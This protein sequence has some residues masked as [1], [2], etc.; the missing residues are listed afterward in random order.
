MKFSQILSSILSFVVLIFTI[1]CSKKTEYIPLTEPH[2][3]IVYT[4]ADFE[5]INLEDKKTAIKKFTNYRGVIEVE[6]LHRFIPQKDND[7]ELY[8][9]QIKCLSEWKCPEGKAI[10]S[11]GSF[12]MNPKFSYGENPSYGS[13]GYFILQSSVKS[14]AETLNF[15][16]QNDAEVPISGFNKDVFKDWIKVNET[17][18]EDSFVSLYYLF[19]TWKNK[20]FDPE[21][22]KV[23]KK[24][25]K[26]LKF[27]SEQTDPSEIESFIASHPIDPEIL[28]EPKIQS[29]YLNFTN[30]HLD[31]FFHIERSNKEISNQF[32]TFA[33]VPYLQELAFQKIMESGE[34][35]FEPLPPEE[36]VAN[37][38]TITLTKKNWTLTFKKPRQVQLKF[39]FVPN[40][41]WIIKKIQSV[42]SEEFLSFKLIAENGNEFHIKSKQLPKVFDGAEKMKEFSATLPKKAIEIIDKF[43]SSSAKEAGVYLALKFGKGGYDPIKNLYEYTI[44]DPAIIHYYFKNNKII[45][46]DKSEI[47]GDLSY[48]LG[49]EYSTYIFDTWYQKY[50]KEKK[51]YTVFLNYTYSSCGCDC[52]E[53]KSVDNQCWTAGEMIKIRFPGHTILNNDF[54]EARVE[55]EKPKSSLCNEPLNE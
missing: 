12:L 1:H 28:N 42:P 9:F 48:R 43:A 49:D 36:V 34:F 39:G 24:T 33:E 37:A 32:E 2:S 30:R 41:E 52:F 4:N 38:E 50:N 5:I 23:L 14:A 25:H 13:N 51:E 15:L 6:G 35:V 8:Y 53:E 10:L 47:S 22:Q 54:S 16:T 29:A 11:R 27:L 18:G 19:E 7:K 45:K 20:T 26:S 44:D 46:A 3:L 31:T 55:F 40:V 21:F 17:T